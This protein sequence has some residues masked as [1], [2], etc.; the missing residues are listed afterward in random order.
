MVRTPPLRSQPSAPS[1]HTPPH[2]QSY[3][4]KAIAAA[5]KDPVGRRDF[6]LAADGARIAKK[7]T[8]PLDPADLS[9]PRPP[10]NVLDED[11]R[12]ASCWSFW[13]TEG[14]VAIK[15]PEFI[16]PTHVTI[17]HV[18]H[19]IAADL[20]QAPRQIVVW[21]LLEGAGNLK[22]YADALD[23]F[24]TSALNSTGEGPPVTGGGSFLPLAVFDYGIHS[25]SHIQ[26]FPVDPP[27][28]HSL[29]YFGVFVFEIRSNWGAESTRLYRVRVHGLQVPM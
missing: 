10:E 22:R 12:S 6:A 11:L 18:L 13:G 17:D 23:S 19:E 15:V 4:D 3:I 27:I 24:R 16:Y 28:I 26:T 2:I 29:I 20:K 21:G 1:A 7:L 8:F 9:V 14:Q 25:G 5:L